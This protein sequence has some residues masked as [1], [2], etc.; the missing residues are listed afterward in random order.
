MLSGGLL[1]LQWDTVDD[2]LTR[3]QASGSSHNVALLAGHG[4]TRTSL[5]GAD[6]SP[7]HPYEIKE[8]LYLLER[9]MDQGARGVSIGLQYEPGCHAKPEELIEVARLVK[10]KNR[11]LDVHPRSFAP[12]RKMQATDA[13]A[14]AI[15]IAR[16]TGV[17]LQISRLFFTGARAARS[18][19]AVLEAIDAARKSGLDVGLSVTPFP[20]VTTVVGALLP[21]W[22]LAR[23]PGAYIEPASLRRL[24][25]EMR[26]AERQ[27]GIGPAD[28][29]VIN[30]IDPELAEHNGRLLTDHARLRR[31]SPHDAL[32]DISRRSGAHAKVLV[33]RVGTDRILETLMRHPATLFMT[34]AW[35]ERFGVQ[36]PAAYGAFPRLLRL[37]RERKLLRLEDAVRKMTGAGAERF[38]LSGR[39]TVAEGRP[40]DLT[41]FDWESVGEGATTDR[42]PGRAAGGASTSGPGAPAG[43][44][45]PPAPVGID[46]VFVNG[47]KI[48]GSGKRE[49]PLSAGVP[50]R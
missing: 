18:A 21:A 10:K 17:R 47:K 2:Y 39:G 43:G 41:V 32:V 11:I 25:R 44:T 36:N 13:A 48:I 37:A 26:A 3:L 14:Q 33:H 38:G 1:P 49:N 50:L 8:L 16:A 45:P 6:P 30:A 20:C 7:L 42:G 19:E 35:V 12:E 15:A 23:G 22:F 5:R 28:I 46:Y 29:Q 4:S 40:A 31:M 24:R 27:T 34:D 9:A